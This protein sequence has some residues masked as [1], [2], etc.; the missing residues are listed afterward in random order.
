MSLEFTI[1]CEECGKKTTE[2]A[3]ICYSCY[4]TLRNAL[5][6]A[7]DKIEDLEHELADAQDQIYELEGK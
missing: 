1:Y 5:D 6:D 7:N 4:D 2:N 3:I